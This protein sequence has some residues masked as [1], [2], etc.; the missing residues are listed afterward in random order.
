MAK[1]KAPQG[2]STKKAPA[3]LPPALRK[4]ADAMKE[5]ARRRLA[6]TAKDALRRARDAQHESTR[7][8]FELGAALAVLRAPGMSE[9]A[10]FGGGFYAMCEGEFQ[11]ARTTVDRLLRAVRLVSESR[12]TELKPARVDALLDLAIATE[13]DDTEAVVAEE[14]V[15][16]W[17]GGPKAALAKMSTE[18]V[19]EATKQVRAHLAA[20]APAAK[21]ARGRTATPKERAAAEKATKTLRKRGSEATVK[22]RAT[23]PGAPSAFDVVGLTEAE[24]AALLKG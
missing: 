16:L 5:G 24:L 14:T 10:G 15:P 8:T 6:A 22:V 7:G 21:K 4:R 11:M 18:A 17:K 12:Y 19:I 20:R 13:A 9:A 2:K 1:A 3:K 23:K